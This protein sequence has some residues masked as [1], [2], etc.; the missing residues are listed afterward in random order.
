[1]FLFCSF[2]FFVVVA[3]FS[4]VLFFVSG[5]NEGKLEK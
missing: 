5:I 4:F 3:L 2:V 1:M